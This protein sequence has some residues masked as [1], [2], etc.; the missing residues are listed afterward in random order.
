MREHEQDSI[1][2]R[3]PIAPSLEAERVSAYPAL[4]IPLVSAGHRQKSA[5]GI[6]VS[7]ILAGDE[8]RNAE[9]RKHPIRSTTAMN[10]NG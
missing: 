9:M 10:P 2:R 4:A 7:R 6:V 5:D 8:G 3:T 1:S